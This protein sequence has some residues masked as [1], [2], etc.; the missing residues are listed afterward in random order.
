[1]KRRIASNAIRFA[2][3]QSPLRSDLVWARWQDGSPG[4]AAEGE[5]SLSH[6]PPMRSS[7]PPRGRECVRIQS[8]VIYHLTFL[9]CHLCYLCLFA[10]G[11][12]YDGGSLQETK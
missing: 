6:R 2:Q 4:E 12:S 8:L 11:T 5:Q 7:V 9:I 10:A 1:M 3:S